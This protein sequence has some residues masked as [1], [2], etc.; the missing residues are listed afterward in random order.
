MPGAGG[1]VC[2]SPAANASTQLVQTFGPGAGPA[3]SF[4]WPVAH[5]LL[6]VGWPAV[7]P[8]GRWV[9]VSLGNA[10]VF[11]TQTH[12]SS[13]FDP[14]LALVEVRGTGTVALGNGAEP[15]WSPDGR[16]LA[17]VRP[18]GGRAHVFASSAAPGAAALQLTD[19]ADDDAQPAWSPDGSLIA[20]CSSPISEGIAHS[21]NLFIVRPDGSGLRQLTEGDANA[22]RPAWSP[23][24]VLYFHANVDGRFHIWRLSVRNQ[25]GGRSPTP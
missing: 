12:K 22:C 8:D 10:H 16:R 24:G 3:A 4:A 15:T 20:F 21:A 1:L 6:G 7:S 13:L 23:D 19:G 2:V 5:P 9:A 18:T 17:F 25:V 14:A 11:Q